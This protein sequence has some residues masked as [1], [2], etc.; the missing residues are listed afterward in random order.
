MCAHVAL[1]GHVPVGTLSVLF[2]GACIPWSHTVTDSGSGVTG[3]TGVLRWRLNLHYGDVSLAARNGLTLV[4]SD[5]AGG[6]LP[7]CV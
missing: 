1:P 5:G 3:V 7:V 4:E 6:H 2:I